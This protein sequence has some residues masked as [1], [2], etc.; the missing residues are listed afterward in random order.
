MKENEQREKESICAQKRKEGK[1]NDEHC[2]GVPSAADQKK[3]SEV[4]AQAE[5]ASQA[6]GE[7]AA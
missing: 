5:K 2:Q 7:S 1:E 6:L 3:M 4:K